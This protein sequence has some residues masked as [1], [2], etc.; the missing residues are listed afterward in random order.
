[1]PARAFALRGGVFEPRSE[2]GLD[3]GDLAR[4]PVAVVVLV[5][6][7]APGGEHPAGELE[8][9][10]AEG[11]LLAQAVCVTAEIALPM[12]PAHLPSC[13][14]EM[15]VA[16]PALRDHDP[17]IRA[18]QRVELLAVAVLGDL[19]ERRLRGGRGP[20]HTSLTAGPPAGLIDMHRARSSTQSCNW[21]CGPANA[22]EARWQIASTAPVPSVT[23]N[24]SWASSV[25]PLREI[26]CRA[27]NVTTVA[28]NLGPN[29]DAAMSSGNRALVR[30]RQ[31]RQRN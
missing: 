29:T 26:R 22:S 16:V 19:Q 14:V 25:I 10:F 1:V 21:Q 28:G 5:L 17:R 31:S 9:L 12:R 6:V 8:A 2:L 18:D 20:R 3:L 11:L 7:D 23:P 24:R 30:A 27:V 4:E 15:A 13:G